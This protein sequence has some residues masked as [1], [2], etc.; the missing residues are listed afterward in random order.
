MDMYINVWMDHGQL[1]LTDELI[2]ELLHQKFRIINKV[3][4]L[5][6]II[7]NILIDLIFPIC[8]QS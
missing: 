2:N 8:K 5:G 1:L 7:Y 4:T 3:M 6:T